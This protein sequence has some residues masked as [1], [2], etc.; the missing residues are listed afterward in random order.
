MKRN[1]EHYSTQVRPDQAR[2][3]RELAE[4][5]KVGAATHVREAIDRYL[6]SVEGP[7][8]A[9]VTALSNC[10]CPPDEPHTCGRRDV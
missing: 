2:K 7:Q 3:L 8:L 9:G 5:T 10:Q 6:A 4:R 1:V